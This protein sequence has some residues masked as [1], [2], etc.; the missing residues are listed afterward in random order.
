MDEGRKLIG[1]LWTGSFVIVNATKSTSTML[2]ETHLILLSIQQPV[3]QRSQSDC[4]NLLRAVT[5]YL[6]YL[7]CRKPVLNTKPGHLSLSSDCKRVPA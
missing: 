2:L 3:R 7:I 6:H 4:N 5:T 1:W